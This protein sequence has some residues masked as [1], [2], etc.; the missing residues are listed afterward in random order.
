MPLASSHRLKL[1]PGR[2]RSTSLNTGSA[3]KLSTGSAGDKS[4]AGSR[5]NTRS[6]RDSPR[7]LQEESRSRPRS[8]IR[9]RQGHRP[10]ASPPD[11]QKDLPAITEG[12]SGTAEPPASCHTR[13]LKSRSLQRLSHPERLAISPGESSGLTGAL[14]SESDRLDPRLQSDVILLMARTFLSG[15]RR[16]Y[17]DQVLRASLVAV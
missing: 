7:L 4:P 12:A 2:R 8:C 14:E 17:D 6:P 10:A 9:A 5:T 1:T 15:V 13:T 16:E 3:G 11:Q